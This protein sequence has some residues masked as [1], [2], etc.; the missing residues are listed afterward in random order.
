LRPGGLF[1][2]HG[3]TR[4]TP[5]APT[6]DP[7]IAR[8]VFPD[9]ELH[10]LVDVL[11]AMQTV[12]LE[13]RDVESLR[14]HYPLTLRRWAANLSDNREAAIAEVGTQRERVWRLYM[15]GSALSFE[16]A[17]ISVHQVLAARPGAPHHLPLERTRLL[18]RST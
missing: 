9:G 18:V 1:L 10:P 12:G 16:A 4:L 11:D 2:N 6:P 17:E 14:D 7:F 3:I 15:L 13:V 8:Y 5:H